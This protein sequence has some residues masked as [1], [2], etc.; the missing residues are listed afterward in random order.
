MS[1]YKEIKSSDISTV[2]I[3]TNKSFSLSS[4]L[5]TI[6]SIQF[7]SGSGNLSGSYWESLRVNFYLSGSDLASQDRKFQNPYHSRIMNSSLNPQHS[8]KF[9]SSGSVLSIPQK[10][11]G[12]EIKPGSFK[13]TD[14]STSKE[15][16]IQDDKFGNLFVVNASITSSNNS[17]SSSD[18]YVGNIFYKNGV[19]L[20]TETGS[21]SHTAS[22]ASINLS[23]FTAPD[24]V[25]GGLNHFFITG[26]DLT[27][28]I[29]FV[30][31]GSFA[32]ETET[33]TLKFFNSGSHISQSAQFARDKVNRVF[34]GSH[35]SASVSASVLLLTNDANSL[36]GKKPSTTL[37]NLPPISGSGGFNTTSGFGGGVAHTDYTDVTRT[38]YNVKFKSTQTI[39][40]NEYTLKI[41][42][43]EFNSTNN[44]TALAKIGGSKFLK[45]ELS[46]SKS[47]WSPYVTTIYFYS[48]DDLY[49][50]MI[51][52]YPQPIKMRD[53]LTL[54]FKI[55][56]D[57]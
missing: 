37:A 11:F 28:S 20:L 5:D 8:N 27:T 57:F 1:I 49:P 6:Q 56:Q 54:I 43:N 36:L 42:P 7:R 45:P 52:R 17:I 53:D 39:F 3:Q 51:A 44:P 21:H 2:P 55:R 47:N 34:V 9:H 24:P 35:I 4:S 18:N 14:N 32:S 38:N 10:Y 12:E 46:G 19:V 26:S 29:K 33:N 50:V 23:S 30:S 25:L 40:V 41:N 16:V 31:T 48:D 15:I 13:L 22:T